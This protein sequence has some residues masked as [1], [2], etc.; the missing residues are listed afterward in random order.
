MTLVAAWIRERAERDELIVASDSRLSGGLRWDCCPKVF[1]LPREDSLLAFSGATLFA[2]PILL[3]LTNSIRNYRKTLSRELDIASLRSHFLKIIELMRS[4]VRHLPNG[5]HGID[6]TDFRILLA[7]YSHTDKC[8]KAWSLSYDPHIDHFSHR[9]LTFHKKK[10]DGT[11]PFLFLG[12]VAK[13][14]TGALYR[15]LDEKNI[16]KVGPLDMEPLEVLVEMIQKNDFD[17]VSGPP[18]I[19]KVYSHA[20][21]MPI[22]VLWP[23]EE[24]QF[25]AHFGRPL[26]GYEVSEYACYDL[27]TMELL[28]P[29]QASQRVG[30]ELK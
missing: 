2:Y 30:T 14:A 11:K 15:K 26:I 13:Q 22:N 17:S 23:L 28:S 27:R 3:Q 21:T 25:V 29:Y 18:Q 24:P 1:P 9:P 16:L 4:E 8:F 7:G 19:V 20:R 12:D 6:S 10:T 5:N